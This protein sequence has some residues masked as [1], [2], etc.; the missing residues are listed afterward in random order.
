[1]AWRM[2]LI[3]GRHE[4]RAARQSR[5]SP[6]EPPARN[7]SHQADAAPNAVQRGPR[8]SWRPGIR[9]VLAL[10]VVVPLAST[11]LLISLQA[12]SSWGQRTGAGSAADDAENLARV[13]S[14]R[15][16]FNELE[17]PMTAVAYAAQVGVNEREL[18]T[19]LKP[20]VP[21]RVQLS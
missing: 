8:R 11:A 12:A 17:V 18:D 5:I 21:Y 19:L 20:T 10:L 6:S 13:A 1:M 15:A 9:L 2:K 4:S 3:G 14:A 16:Q 7:D